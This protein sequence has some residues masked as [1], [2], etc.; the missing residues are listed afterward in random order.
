MKQLYIF[1]SAVNG[2]FDTQSDIDFLYE[3]DTNGIDFD[4]LEEAAY[5]YSDNF[6]E[7]KFALQNILKRKIDLIQYDSF[8]NPY[9]H[10]SGEKTKQLI[11]ADNRFKE[12][13][14]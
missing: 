5:D 12:A 11:Y 7:F 4:K 6:F 2:N 3:F 14:V 10:E 9:F 13:C 8:K 1:G